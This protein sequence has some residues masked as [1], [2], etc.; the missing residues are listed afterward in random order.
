MYIKEKFEQNILED[1]QIWLTSVQELTPITW[2]TTP[3]TTAVRKSP[4]L[5]FSWSCL[6]S[7]LYTWRECSVM[8]ASKPPYPSPHNPLL[9]IREF[10]T[11][12]SLRTGGEEVTCFAFPVFIFS[13]TP[14]LTALLTLKGSAHKRDVC[15][16]LRY[17]KRRNVTGLLFVRVTI[18]NTLVPLS[19]SCLRVEG[20]LRISNFCLF[21]CLV[22]ILTLTQK[23]KPTVE[24]IP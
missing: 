11:N 2:N 4:E 3:D 9:P 13:L 5:V 18:R 23:S 15:S 21:S 14:D 17:P 19:C 20:W 6:L 7:T 1:I 22:E 24:L 10:L 8:F 16:Y 12:I